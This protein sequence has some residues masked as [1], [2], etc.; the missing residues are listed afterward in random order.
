MSSVR[1]CIKDMFNKKLKDEKI[2]PQNE[3]AKRLNVKPATVSK[4]INGE[5]VPDVDKIPLICNIFNITINQFFGIVDDTI[6]LSDEDKF[7]L[8]QIKSNPE[9][10]SIINKIAK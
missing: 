4:W 8:K 7:Y 9:L 1:D 5:I 6:V 2:M 10:I 3:F